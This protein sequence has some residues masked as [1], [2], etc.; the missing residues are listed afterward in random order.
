MKQIF[1][2]VFCFVL[3]FGL[4]ACGSHPEPQNIDSTPVSSMES[5]LETGKVTET[6]VEGL[7]DSSTAGTESKA[8][9]V[10]S[11]TESTV[12]V[13]ST[14]K[15]TSSVSVP[16]MRLSEPVPE[17]IS[18]PPFGSE[19]ASSVP[20]P[21]A[22]S[23][24]TVEELIQWLKD[25]ISTVSSDNGLCSFSSVN[26]TRKLVVPHIVNEELSG[27]GITVAEGSD[28]YTYLFRTYKVESD[29]KDEI[30]SIGITPLT[31]ENLQK[32]LT[33]LY[34]TERTVSTKTYKNI[35]YAYIDGY[36]GSGQTDRA[37]ATAW[38]VKDGYAIKITASWANAFQPWN[39]AWFD[40]F[41]FETITF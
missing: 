12:S 5:S 28:T 1:T 8:S 16:E 23:G 19:V 2:I 10:E 26:G 25:S 21:Q 40:Y 4:V 39:T 29:S 6:P 33:E 31:E 37:F 41:D 20:P 22:F 24:Q 11:T 3:V 30:Y 27:Y 38:F 36:E 14:T 17:S 7:P 35:H 15:S 34:D 32:N 18:E 9:K 13:E